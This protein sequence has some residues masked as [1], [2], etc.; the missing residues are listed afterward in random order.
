MVN[1]D[2]DTIEALAS[3]GKRDPKTLADL[4]RRYAILAD[5]VGKF[6]KTQPDL[7]PIASEFRAV[8]SQTAAA[9]LSLSQAKSDNDQPRIAAGV[10]EVDR[11]NR[12]EQMTALQFGTQCRS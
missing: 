4:A 3:S 11:L 7:A 10:L 6:Q 5:K 2:F 12:R 8:L 9:L 1:S